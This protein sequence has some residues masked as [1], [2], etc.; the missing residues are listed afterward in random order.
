MAWRRLAGPLVVLAVE[1]GLLTP[2][3]E[4]A[5]GQPMAYVANARV[6]AGLMFA[7]VAFLFLDNMAPVAKR[8][9]LA[10]PRQWVVYGAMNLGL[11]GAL[12]WFSTGP[13]STA[14]QGAQA[15]LLAAAWVV[16]AIGVALTALL[17]FCPL[18]ALGLTNKGTLGRALAALGLGVGFAVL[19]PWARS[20]WPQLHEPALTLDRILLRWTYGQSVAG[21]TDLGFPVI[22]SRHLLLLVTPQCS[23]LDALAALWLLG[24]LV[25]ACRRGEL[26]KAKA[27]VFLLVGSA[28]M[29]GLLALRIYGLVVAGIAFSPGASVSLAHS[30]IGG[31]V[32]LTVAAALV[33]GCLRCCRRVPLS[34]SS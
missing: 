23:E 33:G 6:C 30:R 25:V 4:F 5:D 13:A 31:I 21:T 28:V 10:T 12:F 19:V 26:R 9:S 22:G 16:L 29:Y 1:I 17:A 11:Y 15:W 8:Y 34:A 32:L 2:F 18:R 7:A 3:V 27:I 20:W 24:G 14:A